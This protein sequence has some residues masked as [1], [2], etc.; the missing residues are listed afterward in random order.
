MITLH[1]IR[2][3]AAGLALLTCG[4][5]APTVPQKAKELPVVPLQ[6]RLAT[7][8][9]ELGIPGCVLVERGAK[10]LARYDV[11]TDCILVSAQASAFG[12]PELRFILAHEHAHRVLGHAEETH[13]AQVALVSLYRRPL[14]ELSDV[15]GLLAPARRSLEFAADAEAQRVL[16][17][18]GEYSQEAV[19]RLLL[20]QTEET[21]THP[22]G[23][24]RL[25]ELAHSLR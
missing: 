18:R 12:E 7:V 20:N 23:P 17:A 14:S 15:E 3:A 10:T 24:A 1:K 25:A 21:A 19:A 5:V 13:N 4:G 8:A 16:V 9:R 22:A 2:L 6:D 11:L